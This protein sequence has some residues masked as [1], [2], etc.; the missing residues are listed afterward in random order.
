[1][2]RQINFFMMP[3]D[4]NLLEN[5]I[6]EMGF[7]IVAEEMLD[8]NIVVINSLTNNNY[9]KR[10]YITFQNLF[11]FC[12]IEKL[13]ENR[14][15]INET[16]SPVIEFYNSY[17]SEEKKMMRPGRLYYNTD[18]YDKTGLKVLKSDF[19]SKNADKLFKWCKTNLNSGSS[20]NIIISKLVKQL[21]ENVGIE[22][23]EN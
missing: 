19:F 18:Y 16:F 11:N 7:V 9:G 1:M 15:W 12:K 6:K 14:F 2:G 17:Y 23:L 21:S 5:K 4:L 3:E 13:E 10:K 22:L 8:D 20:K